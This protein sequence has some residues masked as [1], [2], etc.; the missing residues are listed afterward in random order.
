MTLTLVAAA[1]LAAPPSDVPPQEPQMTAGQLYDGCVRYV[2]H[3]NASP[4][5]DDE[6]E[7]ICAMKAATMLAVDAVEAAVREIDASQPDTR[8]FCLPDSIS[9][10]DVDPG[11]PLARVFIAYVDRNPASRS[12]DADEIFDRALAEKWPCPR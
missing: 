4:D 8:T 12:A 5:T 3:A 6:G 2:A 9:R 1:L 10:A 11:V 7:P